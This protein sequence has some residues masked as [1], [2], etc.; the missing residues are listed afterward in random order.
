MTMQGLLARIR[1]PQFT[2]LVQTAGVTYAGTA[3]SLLSAPLLARTIGADGRG[4]LASA[5]VILQLL[6]WVGYLGLPRGL[7]LQAHKKHEV[8]F[9]GVLIVLGLGV[10]ST[11]LAW[12]LAVPLGQGDTRIEIG[13]RVSS[14]L[15]LASGLSQLGMELLVLENKIRAY[16]A[17]RS[18]VLILPSLGIIVAY[19]INTLTL[20]VAYIVMLSGQIVATLM[21]CL[22]ALRS[23]V[24]SRVA[25]PW[26]FSIKSWSTNALDAV[27]G[28]GDQVALSALVPTPVLG[29]YAVAV[30][31]ATASA[32]LTSA[33]NT[34][35]YARLAMPDDPHSQ[36]FLRR[37]SVLGVAS[38]SVAG[39]LIILVVHVFGRPLFGSTFQGLTGVVAVLVIA[40]LAADQWGLRVLAESAQGTPTR[41]VQASLSAIVALALITA[42]LAVTGTLNALTMAGAMLAFALFRL[43]VWTTLKHRSLKAA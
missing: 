41:L 38:S 5:F 4:V 22:F 40:Q 11:L 16:N 25:V 29:L 8:S 27:G 3:L 42:S 10:V 12:G 14:I 21:G 26:N 32:G 17:A 39:G 2:H 6:S 31:C 24:I 34:L 9:P 36:A 18:F 28:R 37:R 13:I 43:V 35:A 23:R 1:S 19:A 15:L 30:T 33:L 7:S 20:E